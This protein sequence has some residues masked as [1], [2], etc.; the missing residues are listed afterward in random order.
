LSNS[1]KNWHFHFQWV[2][3][4]QFTTCTMPYRIQSKRVS[5]TRFYQSYCCRI[6]A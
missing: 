5:R 1:K 6:P 4:W 3:E 2:Q